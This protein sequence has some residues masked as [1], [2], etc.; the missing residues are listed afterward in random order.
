[1]TN[2]PGMMNIH[3]E[4]LAGAQADLTAAFQ[5]A[6]N[7]IDELESRLNAGLHQW[8]GTARDT[9]TE[10]KLEWQKAFA[11]MAGVLNQAGIH[12]GNAN[13][14]YQQV[15]RQATSIWR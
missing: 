9:Y 8:T 2:D 5:A 3:Y 1:M 13:E 14:T 10:V 12:M 15:E 4:T 11:H 7:A 6:Q